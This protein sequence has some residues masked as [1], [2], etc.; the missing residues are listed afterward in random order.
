MIER[1]LKS[2]FKEVLVVPLLETFCR[3]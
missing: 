2:G 1:T 3:L